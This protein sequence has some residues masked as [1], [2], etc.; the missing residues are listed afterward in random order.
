MQDK[1]I[2]IL[3]ALF[4]QIVLYA[5][6][7]TDIRRWLLEITHRFII[8]ESKPVVEKKK[9]DKGDKGSKEPDSPDHSIK[10]QMTMGVKSS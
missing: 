6:E 9:K 4:D 2:P 8:R 5:H 3:Q 1:H 7:Y 10:K